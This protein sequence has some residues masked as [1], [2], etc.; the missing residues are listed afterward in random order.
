LILGILALVAAWRGGREHAYGI[1]FDAGLTRKATY[2]RAGAR[3]SADV[4]TLTRLI[5]NEVILAMGLPPESWAGK[6][7]H[8]VLSRATRRFCQLFEITDRL[9]AEQ[10]L[11]AAARWLLSNLVQNFEAR[12]TQNVPCSGP[13]IIASNHPGTVDSVTLAASAGREDLKIIASG[14]PFLRSLAHVGGHLI[15]LPRQGLQE[16]MMAARAAIA[17]LKKGGALLL[18]ARG[19]IDPDPAFMEHAQ[20]ELGRWSRSLETFLR[21]VPST[22][23]VTSIVSHVLDPTYMHHPLTWLRRRRADRQRL[24]MMIQ[25]IQQ[26]LGKRLDIV[27]RVS[28]GEAIIAG[29]DF[30]SG[31]RLE[32]IVQA[33]STVLRSHLAWQP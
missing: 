22:Q 16:R 2:N 7:L 5:N 17:H 31:C 28:F 9:V 30:S 25:I 14:V 20:E 21:R 15:L 32:N 24:A 27:P 18:F 6:A 8:P 26:M 10:G 23:V 3:M 33:A 12:G 13:L 29:G 11:Q 4:G 19:N 1:L